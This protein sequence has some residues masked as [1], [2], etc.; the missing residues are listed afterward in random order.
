MHQPVAAV[1]KLGAVY[2]KAAE[3]GEAQVFCLLA[4]FRGV[5]A[6][7]AYYILVAFGY[8]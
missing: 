1:A 4:V 8:A 7:D 2:F 5:D 6:G 3:L